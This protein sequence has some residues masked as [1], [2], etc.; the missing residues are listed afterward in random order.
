MDKINGRM[1]SKVD[2]HANKWI[3]TSEIQNYKENIYHDIR[4]V[5]LHLDT[6][7]CISS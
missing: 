7:I 4:Y 1:K 5:V 2:R 3:I 6:L